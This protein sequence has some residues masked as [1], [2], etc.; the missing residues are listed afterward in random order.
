MGCSAAA[1][2]ANIYLIYIY[3]YIRTSLV[4]SA[5]LFSGRPHAPPR[6]WFLTMVPALKA[7][8]RN[9]L[10]PVAQHCPATRVLYLLC[11]LPAALCRGTPSRGCLSAG[12]HRATALV[13]V[14]DKHGGERGKAGGSGR[15]TGRAGGGRAEIC[16][17]RDVCAHEALGG[18]DRCQDWN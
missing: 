6:E 8:C 18:C 1:G 12:G 3:T 16:L 14:G 7:P 11:I 4:F 17:R 15:R 10:P 5:H 2:F 13:G 9:T